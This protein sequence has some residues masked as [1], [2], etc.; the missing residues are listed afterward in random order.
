MDHSIEKLIATK[1][2][3]GLS[4]YTADYLARLV[5]SG[6]IRGQKIENV[7]FLEPESLKIFLKNKKIRNEERARELADAR[8]REYREHKKSPTSVF[9]TKKSLIAKPRVRQIDFEHVSIRSHALALSVAVAVV[10]VGAVGARSTFVPQ[11]ANSVASIAQQSVSGF[12]ATFGGLPS[13][14]ASDVDTAIATLHTPVSYTKLLATSDAYSVFPIFSGS[15][16]EI[17]SK[18]RGNYRAPV[19]APS[20]VTSIRTSV[21]ATD[22]QTAALDTYALLTT[23]ARTQKTFISAYVGA[24]V[25]AYGV[26]GSVFSIFDSL[27]RHTGEETLE[28]AVATRDGLR[29]IPP[30][31]DRM[32]LGLGET[33]VSVAQSAIAADIALAYH[34][35]RI[36][37]ASASVAVSSMGA[38]GNALASLTS[39]APSFVTGNYLRLVALPSTLGPKIAQTTF[40]V[41]CRV[42]IYFVKATKAIAGGYLVTVEGLGIGIHAI[43]ADAPALLKMRVSAL[44]SVGSSIDPVSAFILK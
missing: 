36:A 12:H 5:R 3:V 9:R 27:I 35:A 21:K 43:V 40:D 29:T 41:E 2:A 38:V 33:V 28:V 26:I 23:P 18:E 6:E 25:V 31:I 16:L 7:W 1:D 39:A 30:M 11:I 24:G 14:V 22:V 4:G 10:V 8:A 37:P 44:A 32:N 20:N 42:A 17:V 19:F 13:R 15:R 34:V